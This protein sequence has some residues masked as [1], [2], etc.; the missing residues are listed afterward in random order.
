MCSVPLGRIT[1]AFAN[2]HEPDDRLLW[3]LLFDSQGADVPQLGEAREWL[4][5]AHDVIDVIF[6]NMISGELERRF[7]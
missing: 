1:L 7:G 3:E 4:T 2:V 6:R 5:L